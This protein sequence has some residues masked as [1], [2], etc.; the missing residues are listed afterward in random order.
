MISD[1]DE[2]PAAGPLAVLGLELTLVTEGL[3]RPA[4][5]VLPAEE[6]VPRIAQLL[7]VVLHTNFATSRMDISRP[8]DC[9][10]STIH[11]FRTS[12]L[13]A[14]PGSLAGRADREQVSCG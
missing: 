2:L 3:C 12:V 7:L 11:G 8:S 10:A 5:V 6:E 14:M 1:S 13:F 9:K 4:Q